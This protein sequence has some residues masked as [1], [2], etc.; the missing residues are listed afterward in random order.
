MSQSDD[1][2]DHFGTSLC[3]CVN[4]LV[5]CSLIFMFQE[6]RSDLKKA[7]TKENSIFYPGLHIGIY[8]NLINC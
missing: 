2:N 1:P 6:R 8:T 3:V 7:P 5:A 4:P